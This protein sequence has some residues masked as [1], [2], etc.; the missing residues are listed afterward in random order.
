MAPPEEFGKGTYLIQASRL[1]FDSGSDTV[2]VRSP[3]EMV[4]AHA[5]PGLVRADRRVGGQAKIFSLQPMGKPLGPGAPPA[6][7]YLG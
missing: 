6:G 3:S 4:R 7:S 2:L 1:K 5:P